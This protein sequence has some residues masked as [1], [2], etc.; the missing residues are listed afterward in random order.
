MA[1]V[2]A[3]MVQTAQLVA[4]NT[5]HSVPERIA[6]WLLV[7][8]DRLEGN[9]VPMTHQCLGRAVGVRRAGITTAIGRMEEAGLLRRGRG[10]LV[11]LDR[12][13][14]EQASCECYRAIRSETQRVTAP[15]RCEHA[16]EPTALGGE[17]ALAP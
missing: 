11:I 3:R 13:G 7:A 12:E 10:R 9:A 15:R 17:P 8:H 5:R 4:C 6:R 14:L 16:H 2:Q 1:Y